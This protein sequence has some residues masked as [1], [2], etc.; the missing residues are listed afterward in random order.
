[1]ALLPVPRCLL[2]ATTD[3]S[4]SFGNVSV[5]VTWYLLDFDNLVRLTGGESLP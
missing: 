1:M 2:H 3:H 5:A 4:A